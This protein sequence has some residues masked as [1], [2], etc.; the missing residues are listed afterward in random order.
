MM[1]YNEC[2]GENLSSTK[3][4]LEELI[5]DA[6][7]VLELLDEAGSDN[8]TGQFF[9]D[10]ENLV[11]RLQRTSQLITE[12]QDWVKASQVYSYDPPVGGCTSLVLHGSNLILQAHAVLASLQETEIFLPNFSNDIDEKHDE[13]SAHINGELEAVRD[14]AVDAIQSIDHIFVNWH[15]MFLDTP[16]SVY[17][18]HHEEIESR[19]NKLCYLQKQLLLIRLALDSHLGNSPDSSN[20]ELTLPVPKETREQWFS[21]ALDAILKEPQAF[22]NQ[23]T[24]RELAEQKISLRLSEIF[25]DDAARVVAIVDESLRLQAAANDCIEALQMFTNESEEE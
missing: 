16:V 7:T 15:E 6:V 25:E 21:F 9:E 11:L 13:A 2:M 12:I 3:S 24:L 22:G 4:K 19:K 23:G 5:F 17:T 14:R 18:R 20:L 1:A 10:E 8:I